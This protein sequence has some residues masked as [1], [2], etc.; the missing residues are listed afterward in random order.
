MKKTI[1]VLTALCMML[2]FSSCKD[3]E[4]TI[5]PPMLGYWKCQS[6]GGTVA[7]VNF[8]AIPP[9][10][11]KYF[12]ISYAGV[13]TSGKFARIG[14]DTGNLSE[15]ATLLKDNTSLFDVWKNFLTTGDYTYNSSDRT[16]TH[17]SDAESKTYRY[18]IS[19]KTLVLTEVLVE[20]PSGVNSV[21]DII[22]S[23][24]NT[25][26]NTTAGIVYTYEKMS[27]EDFKGLLG[28]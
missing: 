18:A 12:S 16:I 21:L 22:N 3:S 20:A 2:S 4:T 17:I 8:N 19:G 25:N 6:I 26:I 1:L 5:L 14:A 27:I 13:G 23:L 7:G 28:N 15:L 11:V 24:L 10:Y 9:E